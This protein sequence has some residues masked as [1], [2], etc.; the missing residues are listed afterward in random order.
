MDNTHERVSADDDYFSDDSSDTNS[1]SNTNNN[2]NNNSF[3]SYDADTF[4]HLEMMEIEMT[5]SGGKKDNIVVLW[6]DEP[7]AL[8]TVCDAMCDAM[9]VDQIITYKTS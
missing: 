6:G 3:S 7:V 2:N 8:A 5:F 4:D 9:M 1:N